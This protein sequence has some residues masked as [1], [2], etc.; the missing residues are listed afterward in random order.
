M[1]A[2]RLLGDEQG[3]ADLPVGLAD[4]HQGEHFGL[5]GSEPELI[6]RAVVQRARPGR[7]G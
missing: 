1:H 4:R 5:S 6:D 2:R 7:R 3:F